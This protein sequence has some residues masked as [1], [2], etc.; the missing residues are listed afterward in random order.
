MVHRTAHANASNNGN[1]PLASGISWHSS[2]K[3]GN[4]RP[5]SVVNMSANVFFFGVIITESG[6]SI[7]ES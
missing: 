1:L 7:K 6:S 3:H 2:D 4:A 5:C